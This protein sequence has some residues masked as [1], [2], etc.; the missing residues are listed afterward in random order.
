MSSLLIIDGT[1]IAYRAFY[2][3]R[4]LSAADGRPTNAVYGFIR[5]IRQLERIWR[6][7]FRI[8]AFDGGIPEDRLTV[9]ETYKAQREEMPDPLRNQL[10][11]INEYLYRADIATILLDGY[12]ADDVM[13]TLARIALDTVSEVLVATSDKDMFQIV[14]ERVSVVPPSKSDMRMGPAEV[15][16][17][18][19]V[20]P[21][22][23]VD[24]LAMVG[25]SSDNIPGVP[26]IGSKTATR[27]IIEFGSVDHIY[28]SLS[29]VKPDR[30][31]NALN[32]NRDIIARNIGLM[33]LRSDL[34]CHIDW[35]AAKVREPDP[36]KLKPFFERMEFHAMIKELVQE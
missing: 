5:M 24:W 20:S 32:E 17:K 27:L 6:P 31:R 1:A 2:A 7:A 12:E 26:G 3:I 22:R 16:D 14:G 15:Q 36:E 10:P 19:G 21:E 34:P 23:I 18:T 29:K 13:A 25:D 9:L 4:D 35:D 30:I 8:V 11:E 28:E 33:T